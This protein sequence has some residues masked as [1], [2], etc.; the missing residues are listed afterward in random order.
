[1]ES[2][3]SLILLDVR[4][5]EEHKG[6]SGHLKNSLL[7]PVQELVGRVGELESFR[8]KTIVAYCRSGN[9]SHH[10][11]LFLMQQGFKALNMVGGM[12][13]WNAENLPVVRES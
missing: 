4:T 9:R 7:I 13:K 6:E 10:A 1:M 8:D 11:M 2:D 5:P 3:P 12:L